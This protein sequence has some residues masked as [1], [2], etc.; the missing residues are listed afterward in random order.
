MRFLSLVTEIESSL[1]AEL[2]GK[3]KSGNKSF[4]KKKKKCWR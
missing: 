4:Q 2:P 1:P 3:E